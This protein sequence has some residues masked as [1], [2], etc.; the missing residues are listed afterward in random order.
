MKQQAQ[1]QACHHP[2]CQSTP[3]ITL[4]SF[5]DAWGV[6]FS[7]L[8]HCRLLPPT[9]ATIP[10]PSLAAEWW[11]GSTH[12]EGSLASLLVPTIMMCKEDSN[13][14]LSSHFTQH[15]FGPIKALKA[16]VNKCRTVS[17]AT[18]CCNSCYYR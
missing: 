2:K 13:R 14:A 15:S 6:K 7:R 9:S 18:E 16:T 5:P 3:G 10:T 12:W 8:G 11:Q 1:T 4:T 17:L